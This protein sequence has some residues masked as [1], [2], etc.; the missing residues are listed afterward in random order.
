MFRRAGLAVSILGAFCATTLFASDPVKVHD[1]LQSPGWRYFYNNQFDSAI[2]Y[3][4]KEV[5]QQPANPAAYNHLAQSVLYRELFRNGA[6]ESELVTGNNPFLRRPKVNISDENRE[7]F[8]NA[9]DKAE[10]LAQ[11]CLKKQDDDAQA[12][13]DLSVTYG[14]RA[15]FNFLVDKAWKEALHNATESRTY[16]NKVLEVQ[17]GLTD[18]YLIQGLHDYVVG[19]LPF[20]LRMVG[21][22]AG[23]HGDR[24]KGLQELQ[25]VAQHG[26]LNKYDARIL[27]AVIYRRE[28]RPQDAIPLLQDLAQTFPHNDL[29]QLEQVQMYS[30]A[31]N[32]QAALAV[33]AKVQTLKTEQV[34][35]YR[36]IPIEK[37]RYLR[38]NLLFWYGDIGPA[39]EEIKAVTSKTNSLDLNTEV[40]AWLRLGQLYDLKGQHGNAVFAYKR[41]MK[42]APSSPAAS[43]AKSYITSPYKRKSSN[44]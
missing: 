17:P 6:L 30:D 27:L 2:A 20:Y 11:E 9:V 13:Y 22:L 32:K 15:N 44:T 39:L 1:P 18:A 36:E 34:E 23:F 3:F 24:E 14:L 40:L 10:S 37:I 42:A 35:G 25:N 7:K 41:T 8:G 4:S 28:H 31:G 12:L 21:F 16:S 19:S 5:Q 26:V 29:L 33:L 43:E 38:G